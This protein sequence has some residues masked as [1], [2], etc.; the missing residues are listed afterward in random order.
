MS[1]PIKNIDDLFKSNLNDFEQEPSFQTW[2]GIE[3]KLDQL[4]AKKYKKRFLWWKWAS[5]GAVFLLLPLAFLLYHQNN[6]VNNFTSVIIKKEPAINSN[7][8]QKNSAVVVS[9]KKEE[10]VNTNSVSGKSDA[11]NNV[12]NK[13][14]SENNIANNNSSHFTSFKAPQKKKNIFRK[15]YTVVDSVLSSPQLEN[16]LAS[17]VLPQTKTVQIEKEIEVHPM[18]ILYPT[19]LP[20]AIT[21]QIITRPQLS[22]PKPVIKSLSRLSISASFTPEFAYRINLKKLP[23]LPIDTSTTVITALATSSNTSDKEIPAFSCSSS[24]A[25][26]YDISKRIS[27]G[28]GLSYSKYAQ[29]SNLDNEITYSTYKDSMLITQID[30]LQTVYETY[31]VKQNHS[32]YINTSYGT[33]VSNYSTST[34]SI[35]LKSLKQSFIC[36]QIP[37]MLKYRIIDYKRFALTTTLGVSLNYMT[38]SSAN[39]TLVDKEGILHTLPSTQ[40]DSLKSFTA[41]ALIKIGAEYS[42]TPHV[43]FNFEPFFKTAITPIHDHTYPF[44]VGINCG[45]TYH[46]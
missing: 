7:N 16:L 44:S 34:D 15:A 36:L 29:Y 23:N 14:Q 45:I 3:Q 9:E 12:L 27:V 18:A 22:I 21:P 5:I 41:G 31:Y 37:F 10:I 35:Q 28:I 39:L 42:F 19:P 2:E 6:H 33:F 17:N 4:D 46:F 13:N 8:L 26:F 30:T 11:P 1:D 38:L 40:I 32:I 43:H 24:L 25:V 20:N